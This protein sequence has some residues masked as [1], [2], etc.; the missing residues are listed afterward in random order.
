MLALVGV[1]PSWLVGWE[2]SHIYEQTRRMMSHTQLQRIRRVE[3]HWK[4]TPPGNKKGWVPSDSLTSC[5]MGM[6]RVCGRAVDQRRKS[7]RRVGGG[8]A[9]R[10][11]TRSSV[12][13]S[14]PATDVS[15]GRSGWPQQPSYLQGAADPCCQPIP[16]NRKD[17]CCL[18]PCW[19]SYLVLSSPSLHTSL[20]CKLYSTVVSIA[21][22]PH[23]AGEPS[24]T[25]SPLLEGGA[26]SCKY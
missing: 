25:Y 10:W 22:S 7:A 20:W 2:S 11:A 18:L 6:I 17:F 26:R 3:T 4:W 16:S 15:A 12:L 5:S 24:S 19:H 14:I 13:T 8:G 9:Q 1:N 23:G 21:V